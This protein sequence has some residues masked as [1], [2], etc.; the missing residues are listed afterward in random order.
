MS[1]RISLKEAEKKV[2]RTVFGDGLWDILL[3]CFFL[4]FGVAPFLSSSLG[5]F[6]ASAVFIPFWGLVF[7]AVWQIRK[8]VVVPRIGTVIFGQVRRGKLKKFTVIMLVLNI[9]VF[10]LGIV[11]AANVGRVS[12]RMTSILF[13]L[14]LLCFFSLAAYFLD[15]GR[16]YIYGLLVGISPAVGEWLWDHG[17]AS[18]HGFPVT[19]GTAAGIMILVGLILFVRLLRNNPLPAEG[20]PSEESCDG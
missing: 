3:G 17:R 4:L 7:L 8:R 10:I 20:T 5:D 14:L 9:A 13:G 2:F 15:L 12:G 19:F 18:H 1:D 6:W 16:L 11:A